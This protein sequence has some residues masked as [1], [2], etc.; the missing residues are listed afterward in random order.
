M[1]IARLAVELHCYVPEE[2]DETWAHLRQLGRRRAQLITAETASMH[3]IGD[4][5]S[6]AW[7]AVTETCAQPL[8][9]VTWLAAD[10]GG[11]VTVRRA[12]RPAG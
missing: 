3:R 12:P 8:K 4:F 10:A 6:V 7:P 2:L 5:L 1:M 11:D 9:S